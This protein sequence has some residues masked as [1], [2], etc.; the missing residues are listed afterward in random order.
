MSRRWG[1]G[2]LA[3]PS[4]APF[5]APLTCPL[6]CVFCSCCAVGVAAC[7]PSAVR[8]ARASTS[9]MPQG[10]MRPPPRAEEVQRKVAGLRPLYYLGPWRLL[11]PAPPPEGPPV[12]HR[13]L[14]PHWELILGHIKLLM[15]PRP[16]RRQ[17]GAVEALRAERGGGVE[18]V[19][20]AGCPALRRAAAAPP[21]APGRSTG[22]RV[23]LTHAAGPFQVR[24]GRSL[25]REPDIAVG[26]GEQRPSDVR[27]VAH[28]RLASLCLRDARR[29]R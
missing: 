9:S 12:G 18:G 10:A 16:R 6:R 20:M 3:P 19:S 22:P 8:A 23:R 2:C 17:H 11:P 1:V 28:P 5:A 26:G 29:C 24:R 21:L 7:A 27:E 25:A 4:W 13:R 15:R 14:R